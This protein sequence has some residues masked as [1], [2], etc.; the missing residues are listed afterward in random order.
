MKGK[1]IGSSTLI[2]F[3]FQFEQL[4]V[5]TTGYFGWIWKI[6][7]ICLSNGKKSL[8]L[9]SK[10]YGLITAYIPFPVAQE[11]RYINCYHVLRDQILGQYG[12]NTVCFPCGFS[13][14]YTSRQVKYSFE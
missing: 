13:R 14:N 1:E 5:P 4:S 8:K 6:Q 10:Y 3:E 12:R 9:F 11:E 7:Q 2:K